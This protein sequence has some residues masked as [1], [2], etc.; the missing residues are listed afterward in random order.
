M[1]CR[2]VTVEKP[3]RKPCWCGAGGRCVLREGSSRRSR[4]LAIGERR[5]IGRK[6]AGLVWSL[7]G[8]GMGNAE[9]AFSGDNV[10]WNGES[11][12]NGVDFSHKVGPIRFREVDKGA[13]GGGG[14]L[15]LAGDGNCDGEV[16]TSK[17]RGDGPGGSCG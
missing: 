14:P 9:S 8:F 4:I 2:A 15:D 7:P 3:W 1:E 5:E 11:A 16:I 13:A 10:C 12:D 6:L 17:S